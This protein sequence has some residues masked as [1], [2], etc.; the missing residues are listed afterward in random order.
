MLSLNSLRQR[1]TSGADVLDG[2]VE[3][4][5]LLAVGGVGPFLSELL[6]HMPT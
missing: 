4:A 5:G 1:V 6:L 3:P 2:H